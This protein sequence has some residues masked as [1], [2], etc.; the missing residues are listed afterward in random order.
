[1]SARKS[2]AKFDAVLFH[3]E[4]AERGELA[5]DVLDF[6]LVALG[7]GDLRLLDVDVDKQDNAAHGATVLGAGRPS[8]LIRA[9]VVD[10][11]VDGLTQMGQWTLL[12]VHDARLRRTGIEAR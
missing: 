9:L 8:V 1:M 12:R 7:V 3:A 5:E 11:L 10:S 4:N 2:T 6:G